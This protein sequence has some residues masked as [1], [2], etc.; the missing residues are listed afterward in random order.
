MLAW[1]TESRTE[2][3]KPDAFFCG[4]ACTLAGTSTA[5]CEQ[6]LGLRCGSLRGNALWLRH[7]FDRQAQRPAP[8][9]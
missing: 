4:G 5:D 7:C 2:S 6:D 9:T 1:Q 8:L 3:S